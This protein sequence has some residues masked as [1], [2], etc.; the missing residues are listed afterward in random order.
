VSATVDR[1]ARAALCRLGEPGDPRL[2]GLVADVGAPL[3]YDRLL[4]E[5]DERGLASDVAQRLSALDPV[6][7]LRRAAER[8]IRFVVPGDEEWPAR[9]GDLDRAEPLAGRGGAPAGA[10]GPRPAAPCGDG[11]AGGGGGRLAL[12]DVLRR[13]SGR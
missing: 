10:L 11:R 2:T 7:D 4:G 3:V 12:G 13:G 8:G 1:V 9:L 6:A 5:T